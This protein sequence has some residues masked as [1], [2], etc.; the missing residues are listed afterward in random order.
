M[1]GMG[2]FLNY[3]CLSSLIPKLFQDKK[4]KKYIWSIAFGWVGIIQADLAE[5]VGLVRDH[6]NTV[7]MAIKLMP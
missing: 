5:I 4:L 7:N 6:C 1:K 3:F 2:S